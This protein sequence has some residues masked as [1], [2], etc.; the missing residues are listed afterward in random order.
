MPSLEDQI[1][2]AIR[3]ISRA[4]DLRSRVLLHEFGLTAP[5]LA[6]LS[7]IGRL[8]PVTAGRIAHEVHLGQ[9]TV[10]GVLN[11]LETRG[12]VERVRGYQ[13]RRSVNVSLTPDG[14]S[15]LRTAPSLL[16]DQ[17]VRELAALR[18]WER[19]QM[20]ATLQRIADMMHVGHVDSAPV[21]EGSY[22]KL[23]LAASAAPAGTLPAAPPLADVVNS[24]PSWQ[25]S[26][27]EDSSLTLSRFAALSPEPL[28]SDNQTENLP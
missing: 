24:A 18:E 17:F 1:L 9:P 6:I 16:E 10:T 27:A 19:T 3:R 12:L 4:I 28:I 14:A 2:L 21:L 8:Q 23:S 7:V 15:V 20:L 25:A 22:S 13:D 11:R 5:Q 26:V